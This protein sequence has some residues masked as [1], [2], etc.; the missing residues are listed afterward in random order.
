MCAVTAERCRSGCVFMKENGT[1]DGPTIWCII[2]S[3]ASVVPNYCGEEGAESEGK[4][5][6]LASGS[7]FKPWPVVM[8]SGYWP[9]QWDRGQEQPKCFSLRVCGASQRHSEYLG[10]LEGAQSTAAGHSLQKETA[11]LVWI[12]DYDA[13]WVLL[14]R[15]NPARSSWEGTPGYDPQLA[16]GII[17][18]GLG[19][20][21][22]SP[23]GAGKHH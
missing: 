22:D 4:R 2:I 14:F 15:K 5:S 9:Q 19:I 18:S 20:P 16:G 8:S 6:W 21:Q 17:S 3:N 12:S 7:T 11:E 13:F 10:H 23:E 1:W